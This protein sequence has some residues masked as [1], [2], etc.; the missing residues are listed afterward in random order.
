MG[1]APVKRYI[2]LKSARFWRK[3][4]VLFVNWCGLNT[5]ELSC[6]Q[7]V[8]INQNFQRIFINQT[9]NMPPPQKSNLF[10]WGVENEVAKQQELLFLPIC[11]DNDDPDTYTQQDTHSR[12]AS[13]TFSKSSLLSRVCSFVL[14]CRWIW[15]YQHKLFHLTPPITSQSLS[16]THSNTL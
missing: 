2:P 3:F 14:Q 15:V 4:H 12:K 13:G 1:N 16:Q 7:K 11:Q 8:F 10:V 6:V 5:V 9:F